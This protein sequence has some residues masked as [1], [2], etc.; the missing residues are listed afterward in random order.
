MFALPLLPLIVFIVAAGFAVLGPSIT[1]A[2]APGSGGVSGFLIKVTTAPLTLALQ[3][4]SK[5]AR[6]M[7]PV[8]AQPQQQVGAELNAAATLVTTA[9]GTIIYQSEVTGVLA[10]AIAGTATS[11]E[12]THKA[13]RLEKRIGNAEAQAKGIGADVLPQIKAAAH[14]IEAGVNQRIG[15]LDKA[16]E[17]VVA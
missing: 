7:G 3:I 12:L 9:A 5:I 13:G 1:R 11:A 16:L 6:V 4:G 15:S 8:A 2:L 17:R 10:Q 14:G